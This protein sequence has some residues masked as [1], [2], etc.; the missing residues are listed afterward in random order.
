MSTNNERGPDG[1][2]ETDFR[3]DVRQALDKHPMDRDDAL[4]KEI[5]RLR[6]IEQA[7]KDLFA[8]PHP[9]HFAVRLGDEELVALERVRSEIGR[10]R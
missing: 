3:R 9:D 4:V 6:R 7:C 2:F 8:A 10:T 5:K 1:E